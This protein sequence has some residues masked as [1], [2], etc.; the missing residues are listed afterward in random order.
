MVTT[1]FTDKFVLAVALFG[2]ILGIL[3]LV[4]IRYVAIPIVATAIRGL[5]VYFQSDS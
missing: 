3:F 5:W 1:A 4:A 2:T